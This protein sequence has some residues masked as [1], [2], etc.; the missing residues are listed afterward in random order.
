MSRLF[1]LSLPRNCN[2]AKTTI[3]TNHKIYVAS[4]WRNV[5]YPDVVSA[6][7]EAGHEVYDFRN[8]KDSLPALP[9]GRVPA[10]AQGNTDKE[11]GFKWEYVDKDYMQWTPQEY[12][13]QL[14]CEKAERQLTYRS[15]SVTTRHSSSVAWLCTRCSVSLRTTSRRWSRATCASS[16]SPVAARH[17]LRRGGLQEKARRSSAT[18][19]FTRRRN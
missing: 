14:H 9:L 13:K 16:S 18:C 15:S 7:R 10:D 11:Q 1:L 4:S 8:P 19:L 3:M 2:T 5:F 17:I 6:L 12:R